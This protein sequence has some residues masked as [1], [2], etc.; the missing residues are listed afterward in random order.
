LIIYCLF[1]IKERVND[2]AYQLYVINKQIISEENNIHVLKVEF[3]YLISPKHL[4]QLS[5]NYCKLSPVKTEQI[6]ADPLSSQNQVAS[7]LL[8]NNVRKNIKK[9]QW[10]YKKRPYKSL[11]VVEN[12]R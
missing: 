3:A 12:R 10:R 1:A 2:I 8:I 5:A 7:K 11:Q 4:K 9:V 6:I